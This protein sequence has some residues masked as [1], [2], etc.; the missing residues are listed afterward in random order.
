VKRVIWLILLL[1]G[2]GTAQAQPFVPDTGIPPESKRVVINA[3]FA[4][5]DY[6]LIN[7]FQES[8]FGPYGSSFSKGIVWNGLI[9]DANGYP[10]TNTINTQCPYSGPVNPAQGSNGFGGGLQ[11]PSSVNYAGP[12]CVQGVGSATIN[13]NNG[14]SGSTAAF[15]AVKGQE[16]ANFNNGS[17]ACDG[18]AHFTNSGTA[19]FASTGVGKIVSTDEHWAGWCIAVKFSGPPLQVLW[20]TTLDDPRYSG[21]YLKGL[22][23]YQQGDGPALV[24]GCPGLTPTGGCMFRA[25]F[26]QPIV[27]FDPSAIRTLNLM[28][29][30]N[31]S[32]MNFLFRTLPGSSL[33]YQGQL[34]SGNYI[35]YGVSTGANALM[36]AGVSGSTPT[37]MQ[38][39]EYVQFRAGSNQT[40]PVG[41]STISEIS[42][43]TAGTIDVVTSAAEIFS[44]G[45]VVV[46][47][48]NN[49]F[50]SDIIN[51]YPATITNIVSS[52]EFQFSFKN[53]SSVMSCSGSSNCKATV[54]E[55]V[56]LQVGS[57]GDRTPY[58]IVAYQANAPFSVYFKLSA[59]RYY[60][61]CFNK[62]IPGSSDGSGNL[63]YG[64]WVPCQQFTGAVVGGS[65]H[66][67]PIEI[68]VELVNELNA[69]MPRHPINLWMLNPAMGVTCNTYYCDPNATS[70]TEWPA[71][72][73]K[74]VMNGA[75]GYAGLQSPAQL[76]DQPGCN[77]CWN[78]AW[79]QSVMARYR[80]WLRWG[81]STTDYDSF[82]EL[83]SL[84]QLTD[85]KRSLPAAGTRSSRVH[86]VDGGW[87]AAGARPG[88]YN[89]DRITG[90]GLYSTG[91]VSNP[92]GRTAPITAYDY[93]FAVAWYLAPA[94]STAATYIGTAAIP[95]TAV[96]Q[97]ISD[98]QAGGYSGAAA[99]ADVAFWVNEL[100]TDTSSGADSIIVAESNMAALASLVSTGT[101]NNN[102]IAYGKTATEYE[103]TQCGNESAACAWKF[104]AGITS[105]SCTS[106]VA[107]GAAIGQTFRPG[108]QI[109]LNDVSMS[110]YNTVVTLTSV[111]GTTFTFNMACPGTSPSSTNWNGYY[112]YATDVVNAFNLQTYFGTAWGTAY[113]SFIDSISSN[114]AVNMPAVYIQFGN[115]WGFTFPDAYGPTNT[116]GGG[117]AGNPVWTHLQTFNQ[118]QQNYLLKR[119]VDPES[120]DNTP[121]WLSHAA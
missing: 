25:A 57:G 38:H 102:G 51:L 111:L 87:A 94:T 72:A 4:N 106:G 100:T 112:G 7:M 12:Y 85:I 117:F 23:F 28:A 6:A 29:G 46:I 78:G 113:S 74:V 59:G 83:Q 55:Y 90:I 30:N 43:P 11:I 47:Q 44:L 60:G 86:F 58:P 24:S 96:S 97:W 34:W 80:G 98:V 81:D 114:P 13:F 37:D 64:A 107:S 31:P 91:D 76:I 3:Q 69:M 79:G 93:G 26:K 118:S 36:V 66:G 2:G 109:A 88:T 103:G 53:S 5:F 101:L 50:S 77:E 9:L 17:T 63:I 14:T 18:S 71:N 82:S 95:G 15:S 56:S 115:V 75:N 1:F 120:N 61:F 32:D 48:V 49:Q 42:V 65:P 52:T 89:Y 19:T 104:P 22:Q 21:H 108:Q 68:Q 67:W 73:V 70:S 84:W 54:G 92:L 35:P 10:C 16:C 62:N 119:D 8:S 121:A 27:N 20:E 41:A 116:E 40:G 105:L 33:G 110:A 99:L 39:G 45:D